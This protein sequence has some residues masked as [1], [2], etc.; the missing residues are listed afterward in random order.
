MRKIDTIV[1]ESGIKD[2][3]LISIDIDGSERY[4]FQG[5]D[6]LK[7]KRCSLLVLENSVV[8]NDFVNNYASNYKFIYSRTIGEDNFYVKSEED[9]ELLKSLSIN[10]K[11]KNLKHPLE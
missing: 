10:G 7:Y 8:G 9:S 11:P 1:Q 6:L 3:D 2:V 5:L 4:A